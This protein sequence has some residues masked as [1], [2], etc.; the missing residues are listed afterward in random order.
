MASSPRWR[1]LDPESGRLPTRVFIYNKAQSILV[2]ADNLVPTLITTGE[3]VRML[4]HQA[5]LFEVRNDLVEASLYL[6]N[7]ALLDPSE[8]AWRGAVAA[9]PPTKRYV[10]VLFDDL[11][12]TPPGQA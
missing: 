4:K 7:A 8:S 3:V 11:A 6:V 1:R 12:A 2:K 5:S 10:D 9:L